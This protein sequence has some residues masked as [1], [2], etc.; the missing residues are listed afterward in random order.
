MMMFAGGRM[1]AALTA[2]PM[3]DRLPRTDRCRGVVPFSTTATGVDGSRPPEISSSHMRRMRDRPIITTIVSTDRARSL[4]GTAPL[5]LD[6]SSWPATNATD[7]DRALCVSGMPSYAAEPAPEVMPGTS[8]HSTPCRA[9]NSASSPP[10]PNMVGSPPLSRT[11]V[12][13]GPAEAAASSIAR[14]VASWWSVSS[15][16]ALPT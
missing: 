6:G 2:S 5:L 10:R 16:T 14:F 13:A 7:E 1:P 15:P 8:S 4:H 9:R 11:T 12:P 3:S